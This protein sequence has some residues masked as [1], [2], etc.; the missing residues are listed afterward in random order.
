MAGDRK[1]KQLYTYYLSTNRQQLKWKSTIRDFNDGQ[2]KLLLLILNLIISMLQKSFIVQH[3]AATFSPSDTTDLAW[4]LEQISKQM[5]LLA[6]P[7]LSTSFILLMLVFYLSFPYA[8]K[9]IKPIIYC[10]K[11]QLIL[12]YKCVR[13]LTCVKVAA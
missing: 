12:K 10:F 6:Q 7:A 13:R 4:L 8:F 5:L 1:E 3:S 11:D 9:P 2:V